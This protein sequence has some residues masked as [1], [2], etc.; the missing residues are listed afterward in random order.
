MIVKKTISKE[1]LQGSRLAHD[2]AHLECTVHA[3]IDHPNIVK[4][5]GYTETT[6]DYVLL[7]EYAGENCDYLSRKV[8]R[9]LSPIKSESL[10]KLWAA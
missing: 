6:T 2:F 9:D 1:R 4:L 3:S 7:M 5:F 8:L 10:L